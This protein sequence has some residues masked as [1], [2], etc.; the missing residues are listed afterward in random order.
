M[1]SPHYDHVNFVRKL[2]CWT[3]PTCVGELS[4]S[5]LPDQNDN[6]RSK[7]SNGRRCSTWNCGLGYVPRET[8]PYRIGPT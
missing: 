5:A 1:A 4:A 7:I 8:A 2:H 6:P 3:G